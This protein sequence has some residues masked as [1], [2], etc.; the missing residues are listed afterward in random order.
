MEGPFRPTFRAFTIETTPSHDHK[1]SGGVFIGKIFRSDITFFLLIVGIPQ[2]VFQ[3]LY[4]AVMG[5]KSVCEIVL[6]HWIF[7]APAWIYLLNPIWNLCNKT[8]LEN[9]S[10]LC[11]K[12]ITAVRLTMFFMYTWWGNF[13]IMKEIEFKT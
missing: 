8:I 13:K 2:K 5:S 3:M 6:I 11:N 10:S 4:S 1:S 12:L 9:G 7:G